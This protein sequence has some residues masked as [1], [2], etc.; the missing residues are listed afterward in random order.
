VDVHGKLLSQKIEA[1]VQPTRREALTS[2]HCDW[3]TPAGWLFYETLP[4]RK[5]A[6]TLRSYVKSGKSI[7]FKAHLGNFLGLAKSK[8]T[9][10]KA[11]RVALCGVKKPTK[12]RLD[13][14]FRPCT[15]R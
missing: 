9:N 5:L 6:K 2:I 7:T 4:M 8:V 10:K 1:K 14:S 3:P 12:R 11:P 15:W 13:P